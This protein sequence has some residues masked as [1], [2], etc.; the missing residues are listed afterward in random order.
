MAVTVAATATA[1][2]ATAAGATTTVGVATDTGEGVAAAG[3][4]GAASVLPGGPG[5]TVSQGAAAIFVVQ[6]K[7]CIVNCCAFGTPKD[8]N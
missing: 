7:A 8:T 6:E 2:T 3:A 4:A 1:G 5:G